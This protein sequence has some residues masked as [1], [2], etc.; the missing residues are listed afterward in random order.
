MSS[1]LKEEII[2]FAN[3]IETDNINIPRAK[4]MEIIE[5]IQQV[6]RLLRGEK[7]DSLS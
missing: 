7:L 6:H 2:D 1:P 3:A 4:V 5:H